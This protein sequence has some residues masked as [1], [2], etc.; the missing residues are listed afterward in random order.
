[1]ARARCVGARRIAYLSSVVLCFALGMTLARST[2]AQPTYPD[3]PLRLVVAA[4][5]G[6]V[7]DTIARMVA[8]KLSERFGQ[9]V[10][11]DN[12]AGAGGLVGAKMV[13]AAAPNG[14]TLLVITAA[15]VSSAA[16][17]KEA[18]DP[19]TQLTPVAFGA[20]AAII[21]A[22]HGSTPAKNLMD[23][24]RNVKGGRFTYSTAGVGTSAHFVAEYVFKAAGGLDATH[25]PFP[26]GLAPLTAVVTKEVDLT[27]PT[28]PTALPFLRDGRLRALAVASHKRID[29]LSNV[30]TLGEAGFLDFEH[31]SWIG[32]FG[33]PGMS[34]EV[35]RIL[36]MGIN[37]SLRQP[38]LRERLVNLGFEPRTTSQREF[39]RYVSSEMTKWEQIVR[40]TGIALR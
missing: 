34:P 4:G 31:V 36:D 30:P 5:P 1:M 12:R 18:V 22:A 27:V 37:D 20:G 3:K 8:Q 40:T 39:A 14:Y 24:V 33:P 6:G 19:R 7:A 11:A 23:F 28:L 35:I 16:T 13:A 32:F 21:M 2:S 17:S 15:I 10:V 26:G 29:A 25:V 38:D 9:A